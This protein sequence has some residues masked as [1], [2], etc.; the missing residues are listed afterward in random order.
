VLWDGE[1]LRFSIT[2]PLVFLIF[3]FFV[4]FISGITPLIEGRGDWIA[5]YFKTSI[6]FY[7][8]A[9][10]AIIT[11]IYPVEM[12]TWKS[13]M[14]FWV[15]LAL[16]LNIFAIYQI[17]AR[18][19]DLPLAWIEFNN[20]SF[21]R[22]ST[23]GPADEIRQLSLHYGNF[24]R[25]TSIFSEPS[26][27]GAFNSYIL[28]F[29]LVPFVFNLKH[30][31][32]SKTL[33]V[34]TMIFTALGTFFTFSLTA[35]L[36]AFSI[37]GGFLIMRKIQHL[38]RFLVI[39][40]SFFVIIILADSL[41]AENMGISVVELFTKRIEGILNISRG[42]DKMVVGESF[43]VRRLSAKKALEVWKAYPILGIGAGLSYKNKI[44]D[45]EFSDFTVF[46]IL[47]EYGIVGLIAFLVFF[48]SLM[49]IAYRLARMKYDS[50]KYDD[51]ERLMMHIPFFIMIVLFIINFI[52]GNPFVV[53][54][55]WA[56]LAI[57]MS[58]INFEYLSNKRNIIRFKLVKHPIKELLKKSLQA[59]NT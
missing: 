23:E 5:Q 10:M 28:A 21:A 40:V 51:D 8:L 12:K 13:I 9:G 39:L 7:F 6:H 30:Y 43:N 31:I 2:P 14:K 11:A 22:G 55:D 32:K 54:N 34:T 25:A 4:V 24:Y 35:I 46:S 59:E 48:T 52:S 50:K 49:M 58:V 38:T 36:G 20:V 1:E 29:L 3:M 19:T 18:A 57:V 33:I 42:D 16:I 26:A 17:I 56:P 44:N 27:L 47:A 15:V 45:L 41:F 53:I 37:M